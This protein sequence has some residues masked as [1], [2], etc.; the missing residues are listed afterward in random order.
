[1]EKDEMTMEENCKYQIDRYL[2]C[3]ESEFDQILEKGERKRRMVRWSALA[4]IACAAAIALFFWLVPATPSS[5]EMMT[6]VQIAEGIQ[7][8]MLLDIGDIESIVATPKDSYAILTA[9]L[10]D[11]STCS[12]ILK[13]NDAEGTTTL[14]AY[15][16]KQLKK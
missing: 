6:P 9:H 5:G 1:M 14:L 10:K 7:Q 8:M 12:Y 16:K 11:G 4:G 2:D 15:N 3:A 13:C